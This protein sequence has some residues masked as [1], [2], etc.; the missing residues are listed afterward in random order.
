MWDTK[1]GDRCFELLAAAAV[2]AYQDLDTVDR[3]ADLE[4]LYDQ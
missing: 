3:P 2:G 4:I 1:D